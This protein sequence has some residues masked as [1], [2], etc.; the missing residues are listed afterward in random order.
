MSGIVP[1]A[2]VHTISSFLKTCYLARHFFLTDSTLAQLEAAHTQFKQHRVIFQNS[3]VC[4]GGFSLPRQHSLEHYP[5]HIH[6]FG[7][8]N[9]LCLSMTEA[10]HIK[11][12]KEP[13]HRSNHF[14]V[15]G[16]MLLTNQ[17]L[18][19]LSAA[20]VDF[21]ARDMMKSTCLSAAYAAAQAVVLEAP[22]HNNFDFNDNDF[23]SKEDNGPSPADDNHPRPTST[24]IDGL[25]EKGHDASEDV[26][27]TE[28]ISIVTG[29]CISGFTV[30]AQKPCTFH[31]SLSSI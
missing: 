20:R 12:V 6:N 9:G 4:P 29:P 19:K 14:E 13:W 25:P 30:L 5:Q 8:L 3:G 24:D 27:H 11:A 26:H 18:E 10:K 28:C 2:I 17:H 16:Q 7:A 1:A 22:T 21:N 15:L 31:A 23:D